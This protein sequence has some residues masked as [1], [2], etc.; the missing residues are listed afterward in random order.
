MPRHARICSCGFRVAEA[1]N[2][3]DSSALVAQRW[4][5]LRRVKRGS[6]LSRYVNFPNDCS[7]GCRNKPLRQAWMRFNRIHVFVTGRQRSPE[8][9]RSRCDISFTSLTVQDSILMMWETT[10]RVLS[11]Q[12]A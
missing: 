1:P 8:L 5:P 12:N 11:A 2:A 10:Y 3:F 4:E 7:S 6:H 9:M